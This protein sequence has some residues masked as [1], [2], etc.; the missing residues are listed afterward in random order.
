M[1]TKL[2][3]ILANVKATMAIWNIILH[4][5]PLLYA[6]DEDTPLSRGIGKRFTIDEAV[7]STL[8][9]HTKTLLKSP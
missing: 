1:R 8:R 5:D 7:G 2:D 3:A 6:L 9:G 4:M